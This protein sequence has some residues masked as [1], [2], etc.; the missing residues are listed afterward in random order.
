MR[1]QPLPVKK[2]SKTI[3]S[4]MSTSTTVIGDELLPST[5]GLSK[6][7]GHIDLISN[8]GM[9]TCSSDYISDTEEEMC[10]VCNAFKPDE[11]RKCQSVIFV[12]WANS[13][14]SLAVLL[15]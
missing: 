12:E 4:N 2:P 5:S 15:G 6:T 7:G 3:K 10:C 11:V 1:K 14:D 9:S 13:L 8:E